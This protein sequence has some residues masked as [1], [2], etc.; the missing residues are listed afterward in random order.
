MSYSKV[1]LPYG[2][3]VLMETLY[4]A[5]NEVA[6]TGSVISF[7]LSDSGVPTK[8]DELSS[9]GSDPPYVASFGEDGKE[10]LI[11]NVRFQSFLVIPVISPSRPSHEL[12]IASLNPLYRLC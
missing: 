8:V 3:S 9:E 12:S 4:S 7:T 10:V 2:I 5:V 1:P 6:P 11:V